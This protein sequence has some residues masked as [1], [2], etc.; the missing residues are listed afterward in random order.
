ME[1]H[2]PAVLDADPPFKTYTCARLLLSDI[3][4][5]ECRP[6]RHSTHEKQNVQSFCQYA[7]QMSIYTIKKLDYRLMLSAFAEDH[8]EAKEVLHP[9][10]KNVNE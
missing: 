8:A 9:D 5:T 1:K 4:L 7:L 2:R 3:E 10:V 6:E